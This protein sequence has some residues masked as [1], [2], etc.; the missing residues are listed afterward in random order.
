[1]H[2]VTVFGATGRV[3]RATI[4]TLAARGVQVR[5]VVHRTV[6]DPQLRGMAAVVEADVRD[7]AAIAAAVVGASAVQVVCPVPAASIDLRSEAAAVIDA[8]TEGLRA[9]PHAAV[10]AISDYGAEI[11]T[12]TGITTIF[13]RLEA[14]LGE[15]PNPMT[16]VRSAEHMHNWLRQLR[17]A[18]ESGLLQCMHQPLTK[19]FPTVHAPDLGAITAE[20]LLGEPS[21]THSPRILSVEGPRRYDV[22]DVAAALAA[23]TGTPITARELPR[24][25]WEPMLRS[26]GATPSAAALI[27]EL[28]DAHNAGLIDVR[29]GTEVRRGATELA[30]ALAEEIAG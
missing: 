20:L 28:Y 2:T 6:P 26:A 15:L 21:R 7:P 19:S 23:L 30:E 10:V 13:N 12:G 17:V 1:M 27:A 25:Q 9:A 3:G 24:P 5:A 22:R 18:R 29:P 8:I 4:R 14:R 11:P 16:F